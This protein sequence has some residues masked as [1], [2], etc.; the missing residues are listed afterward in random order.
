MKVTRVTM[1]DKKESSTK[2]F[3]DISFNDEITVLNFKIMNGKKGLFVSMPQE[4]REVS[5]EMKWFDL[6]KPINKK[7]A[8]DIKKVGLAAYETE[9]AKLVH[10]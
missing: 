10:V 1:V 8:A 7:A 3:I 9:K 4:V 6:A 2:A 5:D